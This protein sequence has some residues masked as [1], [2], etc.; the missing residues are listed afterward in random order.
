M[1]TNML[2]Q[3]ACACASAC[4]LALAGCSSTPAYLATPQGNPSLAGGWGAVDS[5]SYDATVESV[6]AGQRKLNLIR[7]D[8]SKVTCKVSMEVA[9]FDTL[10]VGDKVNVCVAEEVTVFL[11]K[12]G[13]VP[14]AGSGVTVAQQP[15]M[16]MPSNVM[17][18]TTDI[19]ATVAMVDRSYRLLTVAYADGTRKTVKVSLPNT[20]MSRWAR[21]PWFVPP[22]A[23]C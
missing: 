14:A 11:T 15:G 4:V 21:K 9:A 13:P 3:I 7:E 23:W 10:Q 19:K 6:D 8:G 18:D 2:K 16:S 17:L 1:N 22:R 20:K 12:N 5:D